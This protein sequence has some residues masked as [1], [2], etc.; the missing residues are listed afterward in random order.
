[1]TTDLAALSDAATQGKCP[2]CGA[3]CTITTEP[4]QVVTVID[5]Y[6]SEVQATRLGAKTYRANHLAVIGPDAV[7]KVARALAR[8][9]HHDG[10][11][12]AIVAERDAAVQAEVAAIVAFVG[13]RPYWEQGIADAIERREYKEPTP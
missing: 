6:G 10:D 11:T 5:D 7:E 4:P 9:K 3:P 8:L 2:C 12:D 13:N 1:M